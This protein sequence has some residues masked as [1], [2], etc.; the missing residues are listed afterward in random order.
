M[1]KMHRLRVLASALTLGGT[2]ALVPQAP[3]SAHAGFVHNAPYTYQ[4]GTEAINFCVQGEGRQWH[5]SHNI[6][7]DSRKDNCWSVLKRDSNY[8]WHRAE[9]YFEGRYCYEMGWRTNSSYVYSISSWV[10]KDLGH[11]GCHNNGAWGWLTMDTWHSVA[12]GVNWYPNWDGESHMTRP[13]TWHCH[14]P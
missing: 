10:E 3:A 2:L 9:W 6:A 1:A 8:I 4:S 13:I 12:Y 7:T 5:D 11:H 14:C